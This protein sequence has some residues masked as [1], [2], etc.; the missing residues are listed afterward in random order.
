MKIKI[1][2]WDHDHELESVDADIADTVAAQNCFADLTAD[3]ESMERE[4]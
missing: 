3:L 2:I 4:Q 1:S